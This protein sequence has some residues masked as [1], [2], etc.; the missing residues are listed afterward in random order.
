MHYYL[1]LHIMVKFINQFNW[2]YKFLVLIY[3]FKQFFQ[4]TKYSL[5]NYNIANNII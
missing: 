2:I 4:K 1:F 3:C 5:F